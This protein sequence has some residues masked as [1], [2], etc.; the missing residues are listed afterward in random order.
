LELELLQEKYFVSKRKRIELYGEQLT[1]LNEEI[2]KRDLSDLSE[3]LTEKLFKLQMK[4]VSN[5]K[6]EEIQINLKEKR[7]IEESFEDILDNS[8]IEWRA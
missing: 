2:L 4:T 5:L 3:I 8:Y 1:R 6:Q 7:T